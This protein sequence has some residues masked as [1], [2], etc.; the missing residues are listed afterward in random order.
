MFKYPHTPY[1]I[2]VRKTRYKLPSVIIDKSTKHISHGLGLNR[3][4][5]GLGWVFRNRYNKRGTEVGVLFWLWVSDHAT[6]MD[7]VGRSSC[8]WTVLGRDW[9]WLRRRRGRSGRML[10]GLVLFR[11]TTVGFECRRRILAE[12]VWRGKSE[13]GLL[14]HG[15]GTKLSRWVTNCRRRS[16]SL[17]RVLNRWVRFGREVWVEKF[18]RRCWVCFFFKKREDIF[19]KLY[20]TTNNDFVGREI[21]WLVPPMV[22]GVPKENTRGWADC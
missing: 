3:R 8:T 14:V 11:S 6:G 4:G 15:L 5:Q 22:R 20:T 9:G 10:W 19:I 1:Y 18:I 2:H 16:R 7:M 21:I 17:D 12:H 13:W